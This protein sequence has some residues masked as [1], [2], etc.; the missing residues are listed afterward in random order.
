M[1]EVNNKNIVSLTDLN[2][3]NKYL[4]MDKFTHKEKLMEIFYRNFAEARTN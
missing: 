4:E 3:L 1:A 2:V